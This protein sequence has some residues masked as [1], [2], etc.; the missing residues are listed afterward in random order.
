VIWWWFIIGG[1]WVDLSGR[2][3]AISCVGWDFDDGKICV[4]ILCFGFG[5]GFGL[6]C[7]RIWLDLF[8]GRVGRVMEGR[9]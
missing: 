5:S 2:E 8:L 1:A 6:A 7:G 3:R 4:G 9:T